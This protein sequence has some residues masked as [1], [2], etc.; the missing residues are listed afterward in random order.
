MAE[1][2][3]TFEAAWTALQD[4]LNMAGIETWTNFRTERYQANLAAMQ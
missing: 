2:E 1:D 3:G 4:A